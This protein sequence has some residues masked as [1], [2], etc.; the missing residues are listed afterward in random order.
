M[1]MWKLGSGYS[2]CGRDTECNAAIAGLSM[3]WTFDL[4][5]TVTVERFNSVHS[6]TIARRR[7]VVAGASKIAVFSE[8]YEAWERTRRWREKQRKD[9]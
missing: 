5:G 3:F 9:G 1:L 4:L 6:A 8:D 2:P 7:Q